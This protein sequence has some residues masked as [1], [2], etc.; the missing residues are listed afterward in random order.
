MIFMRSYFSKSVSLAPI[1][2][3]MSILGLERTYIRDFTN[4]VSIV[5]GVFLLSALAQL[6]FQLPWT[7]IPITGQ[8]FGVLF[9]SLMLGRSRAFL[10][11]LS[12]LSVGAIGFPV[13]AMAEAGL[14]FGPRSGYLVGMLIASFVVGWLSD[15]GWCHKFSTCILA[16]LVSSLIVVS[17][18]ENS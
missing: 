8:T 4:L 1:P 13:F 7:P 2:Y 3:L 10:S 6:S 12:Y 5:L 15:R 16:G 11:V 14:K 18:L 9:I 17:L